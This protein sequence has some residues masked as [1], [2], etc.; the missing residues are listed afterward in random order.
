[1]FVAYPEM[2]AQG[3]RR[4]TW[5]EIFIFSPF[6]Y[7]P[8]VAEQ[9]GFPRYMIMLAKRVVGVAGDTVEVRE[10]GRVYVNGSMVSDSSHRAVEKGP[11]QQSMVERGEC[12]F[13]LSPVTVPPGHLFV[14][15]DNHAASFDSL[16]FGFVPA[17]NVHTVYGCA[18]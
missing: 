13:T 15:G 2:A 16:Y 18:E 9:A 14:L 6:G 11:Q 3:W 7:M 4:S 12:K 8:F 1:L 10:N 17:G 5:C